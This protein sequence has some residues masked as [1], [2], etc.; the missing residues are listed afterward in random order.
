MQMK[1]GDKA[2][3]KA[4]KVSSKTSVRKTSKTGSA[5]PKSKGAK[6]AKGA[7]QAKVAKSVKGSKTGSKPA[8]AK[9][10]V[11]S[12]NGARPK[13]GIDNRPALAID[14]ATFSN[15]AVAAAFKRAVKKYPNAFRRLT[16]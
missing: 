10:S 13:A 7:K 1:H 15:P 11:R 3:A 6:A 16:D 2:K 14:I 8:P 12:D 5:P 9:A 4:A